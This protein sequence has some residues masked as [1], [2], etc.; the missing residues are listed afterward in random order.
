MGLAGFCGVDAAEA[1]EAA[2]AGAAA[3][4][5]SCG[6]NCGGGNG[7]CW[8]CGCRGWSSR[9]IRWAVCVERRI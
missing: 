2:E 3:G 5:M 7:G 4:A 8:R 9:L 6:G 1:Q